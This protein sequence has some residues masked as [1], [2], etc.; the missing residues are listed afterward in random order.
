M[1]KTGIIW[2]QRFAEHAMGLGHAESPSR[3]FA[4]K[5]ILDGN[6]VGRELLYQEARAATKEELT[7]IHDES[8]IKYIEQTAGAERTFLDPDTSAN[9]HTWETATLAAGSGIV[10]TQKVVEEKLINAFALVR[11]PGHHAEK[12]HAMG[13]CIFNN[14]AIA[15]KYATKY[16]GIERI[17]IIDFDVHHGNG[18]QN[19]FYNDERVLYISTH[20]QHF[21][22]GSGGEN[23]TGE[24]KG[25]GTNLNIPL[26]YGAD[27]DVYKR[28]FDKKIVP[29]V[30]KFNP[31][32]MLVSAGYDAHCRDP[33]GGMKVT[34]E[35][36]RWIT[37]TL[38]E[39]AKEYCKGKQVYFLEGGYDL[40][41]LRESV[42]ATLEILVEYS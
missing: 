21:Y 2:D 25:S 27:D 6:G 41:A 24:G 17:A 28:I 36:F 30:N 3:L 10:L 29:A 13:F 8:Y 22:P 33:L 42:E 9:A 12:N 35:G 31:E 18:T 11:P 5:E 14:I 7:L 26:E 16:L 20:R 32:L 23:E 38:S 34:T 37:Q 4:I 39:L 40:K 19:A 15:A 1:S